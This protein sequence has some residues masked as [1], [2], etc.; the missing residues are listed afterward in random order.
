MSIQTERFVTNVKRMATEITPEILIDLEIYESRIVQLLNS[1]DYIPVVKRRK[2]WAESQ[3][4]INFI[5]RHRRLMNDN[6][7]YNFPNQ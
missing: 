5:N 7:K 1:K 4:T 6:L 3:R 2:L